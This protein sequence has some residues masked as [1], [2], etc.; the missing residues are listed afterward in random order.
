MADKADNT[1]LKINLEI[2][3]K[4]RR[5][6]RYRDRVKQ[7]K[8]GRSKITKENSTNKSVESAQGQIDTG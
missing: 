1:T 4:E 8:V 3:V 6:K 7:Y 5:S 2:L